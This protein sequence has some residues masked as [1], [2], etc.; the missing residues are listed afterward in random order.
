M[1]G[2]QQ[3]GF[4]FLQVPGSSIAPDKRKSLFNRSGSLHMGIPMRFMAAVQPCP[5]P[6]NK[7]HEIGRFEGFMPESW[8][9]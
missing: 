5:I 1:T 2:H 9:V 3:S 4:D 8:F 6:G 7:K